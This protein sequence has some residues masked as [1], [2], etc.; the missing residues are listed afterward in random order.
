MMAAI[1][2]RDRDTASGVTYASHLPA[3]T[4]DVRGPGRASTRQRPLCEVRM[5][6]LNVGTM[7]GKA[8]EVVEMMKRRQMEVLCVQATKWKGDR[9]RN[10]A[11]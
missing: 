4:T 2:D 6:S 5:G 11:E 10:M 1:L 3:E 7:E 8:L 9:A